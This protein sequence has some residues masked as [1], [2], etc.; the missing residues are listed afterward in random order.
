M[1]TFMVE[2]KQCLTSVLYFRWFKVSKTISRKGDVHVGDETSFAVARYFLVEDT[3]EHQWKAA[4][5]S[6]ESRALETSACS[7]SCALTVALRQ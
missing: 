5:T 6:E 1:R 7:L 4:K 2:I 3:N